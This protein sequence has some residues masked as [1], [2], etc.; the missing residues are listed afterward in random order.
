MVVI[1]C[2]S[3]YYRRILKINATVVINNNEKKL[4]FPMIHI[5]NEKGEVDYDKLRRAADA[6]ENGRAT[7]DRLL[8][9][10]ERGR[11]E[12]GRRNVEASL[13]LAGEERTNRS[14]EKFLSGTELNEKR[15][16]Q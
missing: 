9:E 10:A 8:V 1:K 5:I 11:K 6:I 16:R 12:G 13:I 15:K 4:A 2:I 3:I 7:L 14:T